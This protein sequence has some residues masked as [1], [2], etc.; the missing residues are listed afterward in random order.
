MGISWFF[1]SK[2]ALI[3][4]KFCD[5]IAPL[6]TPNIV[7]CVHF[8]GGLIEKMGVP[9]EQEIDEMTQ[10]IIVELEKAKSRDLEESDE[11]IKILHL[12]D[13]RNAKWLLDHVEEAETNLARDI[14]KRAVVKALLVTTWQSRLYFIIRSLI[15]G[16][17]STLILF[18]FVL[19]FNS[20]TLALEIPLG[21][22]TFVVSLAASRLFDVQIV[23]ATKAVVKF[24]ANHVSLREFVLDH[25]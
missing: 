18:I 17:F 4:I 11:A 22:F 12:T 24:L 14:G 10:K 6:T 20:I 21:I 23:K 8:S 7:G 9:A 5:C 15:M 1:T 19:I 16:L 3:L 13:P 25:F 2:F